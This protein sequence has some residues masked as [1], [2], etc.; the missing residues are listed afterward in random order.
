[1]LSIAVVGYNF[2][3][4]CKAIRILAENDN[5]TE[6]KSIYKDYIIMKDDTIYKTFPTYNHA[7]GHY[8]DQL[9]VVDDCRWDIY[10][11]QAELINW[12]K[13]RINCTSCVPEEFQEIKYEW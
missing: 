9:I 2:E 13:Y 8:I 4:S 11:K 6:I 10:Y 1:M 5:D 7:R 3:L 12:I